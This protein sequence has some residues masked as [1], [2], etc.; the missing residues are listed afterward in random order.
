MEKLIIICDNCGEDMTNNPTK[1]K[2]YMEVKYF[3][4]GVQAIVNL[5]R[6]ENVDL[7]YNCA[8]NFGLTTDRREAK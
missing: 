8:S 1:L 4:T 5:K 6:R 3:V 7:C 2:V